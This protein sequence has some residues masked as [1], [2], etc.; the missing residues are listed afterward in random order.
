MSN[1][2][3]ASRAAASGST[4]LC[5][6]WRSPRWLLKELHEFVRI[7]ADL[8]TAAQKSP[9]VFVARACSWLTVTVYPKY[10]FMLNDMNVAGLGTSPMYKNCKLHS[11]H[12]RYMLRPMR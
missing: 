9:S 4:S 7:Q 11:D 5:Q 2:G 3:H 8:A 6:K 10:P 1:R 12:P